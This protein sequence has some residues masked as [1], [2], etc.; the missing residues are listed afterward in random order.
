MTYKA[1]AAGTVRLAVLLALAC[2]VAGAAEKRG[3]SDS[4][5]GTVSGKLLITGSSTMCPLIGE[6]GRRFETLHPEVRIEVQCGGSGRGIDDVREGKAAIGMASRPLTGKESDLYCVPIARDG[7]SII[8][9]K[10]NPVKSLSD[11]QVAE[12]YTG[13]L[14]NWKK[15][16]GRNAPITVLNA[17]SGYGSVELFTHYLN[18]KYDE[19]KAGQVV[20]DNPAR[21]RAV[22]DN[23]NAIAY[24]S[25]GEAERNALAGVPIKLLPVNGVMPTGRNIITGNYPVTRPLNLVTKVL[26]S[27]MAKAFIDYCLT[28]AVV[29]LIEKYDFIPYED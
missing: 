5:F 15:V 12:I 16:G 2:T 6:I 18:I 19:I 8:L 20:G 7:V 21:F 22:A 4:T 11:A 28:S 1:M 29:D 25:S 26:P 3:G 23:P 13:R 9:H 14:T 10:D 17:K 27:G 24:A